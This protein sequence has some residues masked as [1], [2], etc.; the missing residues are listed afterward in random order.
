[1]RVSDHEIIEEIRKG[2][3]QKFSLLVDRYKDRAMTLA[4][5]M[6]RNREDAEETVQDAFIRAYKGL[7][8]FEGKAKFSTWLYR[9]VYNLCLT[10]IGKLQATPLFVDSGEDDE[11]M[12][13]P[14]EPG[15]DPYSAL[16]MKDTIDLIKK[17]VEEMPGRYS[18]VLSL[19]YFQELSYDEICAVTGLPLGTVKAHLFR[20][21][22]ML[23]KRLAEQ[24]CT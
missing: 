9:I 8:R 6:V 5:R 11:A 24:V 4:V 7:E 23:Q 10:K 15:I 20:A 22:N 1:M 2:K 13:L 16:E 17:I 18:S 14:D 3:K 12:V 21:R 19:F